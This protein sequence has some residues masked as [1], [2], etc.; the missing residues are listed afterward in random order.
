MTE[1]ISIKEGRLGSAPLGGG[2]EARR[3][4]SDQG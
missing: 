3:Q 1:I 2:L 4:G